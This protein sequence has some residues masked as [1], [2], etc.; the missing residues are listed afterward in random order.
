MKACSL[1]IVVCVNVRDSDAY[2]KGT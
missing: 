1:F 2:S